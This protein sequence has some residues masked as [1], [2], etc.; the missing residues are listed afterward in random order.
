[1]KLLRTL[2]FVTALTAVPALAAERQAPEVRISDVQLFYRVFDAANGAPSAEALQRDYIE[3]GTDGVRQFVPQRIVSGEALA[4]RIAEKRDVYEKA[5]LCMAEL[6]DVRDRVAN[7]LAKLGELLPDAQFPPV[8]ILIGRTNSGG[9]TGTAG[10][11]I[12]LEVICN[13]DWLEPNLEDRLVHLIAHEYIHVQQPIVRGDPGH[14]ND[15]LTVLQTALTE[16][17]ADFVGEL[18]SGSVSNTHLQ[19]WLAGCDAKVAA[20][21]V[22]E[23]DSTDLSHWLYNGVG[24]PEKPGDLGYWAGYRIAKQ[25]YDRATDKAAA[26]QRLVRLDDAKAIFTESG[27]ANSLPS[28]RCHWPGRVAAGQSFVR[29]L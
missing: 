16:G 15:R 25:Y 28:D 29:K 3:A 7:T 26:V 22:K 4:K 12:G 27:W 8:T 11:L 18:I 10:V 24:T 19:R 17:T 13:A 9:T 5:R 21:L 1:M 23:I 6:P 20:L 14:A 2:A